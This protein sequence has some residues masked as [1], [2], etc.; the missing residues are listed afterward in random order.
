[1]STRTVLRV[2]LLWLAAAIGVG[3]SGVLASLRFPAPQLVLL[4]ITV[5]CLLAVALVPRL[6]GWALQADERVLVAFHLTRF[7]GAW[8]LV[9][10]A[11][12]RLP[13]L[14]AVVGGWGDILVAVLAVPLLLM[15]RADGWRRPVY[16]VWNV[17][18]LA[19]ILFVVVTAA[20]SAMTDP[21][22]MQV[23]L[24]PPLNLLL[25]FVVPIILVTHLVLGYRL[26]RGLVG[27]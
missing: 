4:G 12:G 8:F 15:G 10:F 26:S 27:D 5:V 11:Q 7:V 16:T 21:A 25:T 3:R 18:G 9:L 19:D 22:S 24:L 1:M 14:F 6:R 13:F 20:R 23:L 17:V 2:L